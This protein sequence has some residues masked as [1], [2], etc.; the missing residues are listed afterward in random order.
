MV[1]CK[2]LLVTVSTVTWQSL[3]SLVLQLAPGPSGP[4]AL[5]GFDDPRVEALSGRRRRDHERAM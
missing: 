5:E 1:H 2:V 3:L 4:R